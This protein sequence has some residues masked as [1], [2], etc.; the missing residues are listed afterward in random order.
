MDSITKGL[1]GT[2]APL[3]EHFGTRVNAFTWLPLQPCKRFLLSCST[4]ERSAARVKGLKA[5]LQQSYACASV[6]D[7]CGNNTHQRA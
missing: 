3:H 7:C 5:S 4:S 1:L 2:A 6:P